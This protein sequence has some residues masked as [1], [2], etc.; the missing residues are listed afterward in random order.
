MIDLNDLICP[1]ADSLKVDIQQQQQPQRQQ[2]PRKEKE[3]RSALSRWR[4]FN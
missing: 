3:I 2:N 1:G 4:C